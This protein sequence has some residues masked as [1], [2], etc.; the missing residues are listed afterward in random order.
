MLQRAAA[1]IALVAVALAVLFG[2]RVYAFCIPM[3]AVMSECCCQH[4]ADDDD[5]SSPKVA[6]QCCETRSIDTLPGS[7]AHTD[8]PTLDDFAAILPDEL[9]AP[10]VVEDAGATWSRE[11]RIYPKR[12]VDARAGPHPPLYLV[13]RAFLI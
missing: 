10:R 12:L 7:T 8:P 13:N 2:G 5:K 1:W 6:R 3:Q 9:M 11:R 4:R